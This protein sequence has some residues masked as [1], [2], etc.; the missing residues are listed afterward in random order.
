MRSWVSTRL[1]RVR[2]VGQKVL[3]ICQGDLKFTE[4]CW[5]RTIWGVFAWTTS[6]THEIAGGISSMSHAC[7]YHLHCSLQREAIA[8]GA[9]FRTL[10]KTCS[11]SRPAPSC[12]WRDL[13]S[14]DGNLDSDVILPQDARF[15][16]LCEPA[17]ACA[18]ACKARRAELTTTIVV[19]YELRCDSPKWKR[20]N[21]AVGSV[22]FSVPCSGGVTAKRSQ[23][24]SESN[25]SCVA[26]VPHTGIIVVLCQTSHRRL[27][28]QRRSRHAGSCFSC[29]RR[30]L[31]YRLCEKSG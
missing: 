31:R 14:F 10:W 19:V 17:L 29:S 7:P 9:G 21:Q 23:W 30:G 3:S 1:S 22:A 25:A 12:A 26:D 15:W 24:L 16:Q 11:C 28:Q 13:L 5:R 4:I 27:S 18:L 2:G 8:V 20:R 6:D